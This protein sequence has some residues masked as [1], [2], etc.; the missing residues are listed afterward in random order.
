MSDLAQD[1]LRPEPRVVDRYVIGEEIASGGMATVHIGRLVGPIGFARTVAIKRLHPNLAKDSEFVKMFMDEA[2][3]AA[4]IRHP[5][6]IA[7]IDVLAREDELL[8]VLEYVNGDSLAKLVRAAKRTEP[9]GRVPLPIAL[10]IVHGV[11]CGLHAAHEA[12]TE[13]GAPMGIVHRDVSPQNILVGADGVPRVIDFGVA[14]AFANVQTTR[15]GQ[16]KGKLGYMSPEQVRGDALDRRADVFAA[17]VVLWELVTGQRLFRH[18]EPVAV[19]NEVL[20][21]MVLLPSTYEPSLPDGLDEV[22]MRGV[23]VERELRYETCRD[24]AVAIERVAPMAN[25]REVGEWVE[26]TAAE[27]LAMRAARVAETESIAPSAPSAPGSSIRAIP[28]VPPP[29]PLPAIVLPGPVHGQEPRRWWLLA[30][31]FA[32]VSIGAIVGVTVAQSG[33]SGAPAASA[34]AAS[35]TTT[36]D[37]PPPPP[38]T[39]DTAAVAPSDLPLAT[40]S[41]PP[42]PPPT[43]PP[44]AKP[45]TPPVTVVSPHPAAKPAGDSVF[46]GRK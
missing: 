37:T 43:R 16:L 11:L 5:N 4:R 12:T 14:K 46:D 42:A 30:I 1:R 13:Q 18:E 38:P 19:I 9:S 22:V 26:R 23:A 31:P 17:A 28:V 41:T 25:T 40:A 20:A 8:L 36:P 39:I 7:T 21:G 3:L 6:V 44:V 29:P 35:A 2:R 34:A 24:F 10:A 45:H 27:T 32:L 15:D 33:G